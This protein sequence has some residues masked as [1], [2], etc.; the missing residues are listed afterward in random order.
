M[1]MAQGR[2]GK[3]PIEYHLYGALLDYEDWRVNEADY[4][5]KTWAGEKPGLH[6]FVDFLADSF[7]SVTMTSQLDYDHVR[8]WWMTLGLLADSTKVTRLAQLRSF[9]GYCV[10]RGWLENDPSLLLRAQRPA[11]VFRD[12]L[13]PAELLA[14]TEAATS[15]R[16][17]A[18]IGLATNLALR[19]GEIAGLRIGDVNL[20]QQTI[21]VAITKTR[22]SDEMPITSDLHAILDQ[23]LTE[24]TDVCSALTPRSYLIP[25]RYV[26][27]ENAKIVYRHTQPITKPYRVVQQALA[28]IGWD[29]VKG[30]GV[31]TVRRS[32]ARI[33]FDMI[34]DD[35]TFDSALLATM[36][37]LH[38]ARSDTTLA[39]IGRD[40]A[41]LA[42]DRIL[43]G[44]PFLTR[45][46]GPVTLR[47]VK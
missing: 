38:H 33:Y 43:K 9:L 14:L 32:V 25:S 24:Y 7:P 18:L 8:R 40:R 19:G 34:E 31:H 12:R 44:K 47:A 46:A 16:D 17:R 27:R 6:A 28:A 37:L 35:E 23:W 10:K 30:E 29:D 39:Y 4:S 20:S 41:T 42:R 13:D 2:S 11:S 1:T 21:R 3:R 5:P 45:L 15:Q 22:D 26:D 36:T